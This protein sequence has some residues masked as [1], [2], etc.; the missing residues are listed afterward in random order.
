MSHQAMHLDTTAPAPVDDR[1]IT[2][3]S[4]KDGGD[5]DV[6]D[7]AVSVSVCPASPTSSPI[8]ALRNSLPSSSE[9]FYFLFPFTVNALQ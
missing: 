4:Q 3:Q 9:T 5:G 8:A 7:G 6:L 2:P 1:Q